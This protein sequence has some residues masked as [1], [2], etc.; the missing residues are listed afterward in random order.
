MNFLNGVAAKGLCIVVKDACILLGT[1][2]GRFDAASA[3]Q[4]ACSHA[5]WDTDPFDAWNDESDGQ[6][7]S[8]SKTKANAANAYDA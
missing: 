4:A 3:G 7:G 2:A 1:E 6:P 5:G 8:L